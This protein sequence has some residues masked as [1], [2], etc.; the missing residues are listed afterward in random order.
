[1]KRLQTKTNSDATPIRTRL[2]SLVSRLKPAAPVEES[3]EQAF[4][5][6]LRQQLA[7]NRAAEKAVQNNPPPKDVE[8]LRFVKS[9]LF[10]DFSSAQKLVRSAETNPQAAEKVEKF[11]AAWEKKNQ[12]PKP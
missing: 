4:E 10:C 12:T 7:D 2:R 6:K 1:M 8:F 3:E 9:E 5:R 11:R